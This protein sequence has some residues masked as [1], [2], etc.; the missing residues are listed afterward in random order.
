MRLFE[1]TA[2]HPL[3]S[4]LE[5]KM[6]KANFAKTQKE[7]FQKLPQDFDA[8]HSALFSTPGEDYLEWID[9]LE[10]VTSAK[11]RFVMLELGA[12]YGRWCINAMNALKLLNPIPFHFVAVEAEVSHF[13]FL[14]EYF[15]AHGL[16]LK[17]HRLIEAA[18][19]VDKGCALFHMGDPNEWYGQCIDSQNITIPQ[20]IFYSL[21][22]LFPNSH[23]KEE[24]KRHKRIVKTITLNSILRRYG[25]VDLIDMDIQGHEL[26]VLKASIDLLNHKVKRLHIGTHSK[27]IDEGL[28][29]L[30]LTNGWKN[31][32]FYSAFTVCMTPYGRVDFND[33]IQSWINPNIE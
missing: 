22:S 33:G 18:I 26:P 9:I 23:N 21:Q 25:R 28:K 19:D 12:G 17:E 7:I 14:K 8:E 11:N 2:G 6:Q 4:L 20:K 24:K 32:H 3:H 15:I 31:V 30:F 16:H 29:R 1:K 10:A 5:E 13:R 27:E